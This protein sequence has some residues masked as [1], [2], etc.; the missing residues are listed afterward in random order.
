MH[1]SKMGLWGARHILIQVT[2]IPVDIFLLKFIHVLSVYMAESRSIK[3]VQFKCSIPFL[4]TVYV[5][6]GLR[7]LQWRHN[8]CDGVSNHRRL[9]CLLNR[10]FRRKSKKTSKLHKTGLCTGNSPMT[11]EF[12]AQ[13]ASNAKNASIWWL[14]YD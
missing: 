1:G 10:L 12:P 4:L 14:Y 2:H 9:D 8:E 3:M 11:G 5:D 13:T 6:I 7:P